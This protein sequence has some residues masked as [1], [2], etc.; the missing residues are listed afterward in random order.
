MIG[1]SIFMVEKRPCG[2]QDFCLEMAGCKAGNC[3]N[4]RHRHSQITAS[5]FAKTVVQFEPI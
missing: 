1:E 3:F 2:N 4:C 5:L